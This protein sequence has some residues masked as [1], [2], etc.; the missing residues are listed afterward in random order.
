MERPGPTAVYLFDAKLELGEVGG[1]ELELLRHPNVLHATLL[2]QVSTSFCCQMTG[3]KMMIMMRRKPWW[4]QKT[5]RVCWELNSV[6]VVLK[7]LRMFHTLLPLQ[8]TSSTINIISHKGKDFYCKAV[9]KKLMMIVMVMVEEL[10]CELLSLR[11]STKEWN[12]VERKVD[13]RM[14]LSSWK[15][16][17]REEFVKETF[18]VCLSLPFQS[19]TSTE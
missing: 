4:V 12:N 1:R 10:K 14:S 11:Q 17:V 3:I 2:V 18:S 5:W 19:K 9:Q 16:L 8:I 13:S 6:Q 7:S 15:E